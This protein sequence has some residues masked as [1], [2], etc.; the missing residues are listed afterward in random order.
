MIIKVWKNVQ[1]CKHA[2]IGPIVI[3]VEVNHSNNS[4]IIDRT[5]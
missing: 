5:I 3:C 1:G 2:T 4:S